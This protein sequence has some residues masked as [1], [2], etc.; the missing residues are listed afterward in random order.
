MHLHTSPSPPTGAHQFGGEA[1]E[2]HPVAIMV[3]TGCEDAPLAEPPPAA[4]DTSRVVPLATSRTN[5]SVTPLSSF[6]TRSSAALSKTT[7][8][9]LDLPR[10]FE[11][12]PLP[13]TPAGV[14]L[15]SSW[16]QCWTGSHPASNS[17]AVN[18]AATD[19]RSSHRA[20]LQHDFG[21]VSAALH[22]LALLAFPVGVA[23][24]AL[25]ELA[26]GLAG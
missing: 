21:P 7:T 17:T 26:G 19:S 5:T 20:P 13:P 11:D 24:L 9:G 10:P 12:G 22:D 18:P 15:T 23:E 2:G 1:D 6:G 3:S 8:S 4:T 14:S 25:E 16:R